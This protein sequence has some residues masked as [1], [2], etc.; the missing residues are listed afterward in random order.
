MMPQPCCELL[1]GR[2]IEIIVTPNRPRSVESLSSLPPLA[3]PVYACALGLGLGLFLLLTMGGMSEWDGDDALYIM[4]ARN[5]VLGLPYA[6]TGYILNPG[7]VINPGAYPPGFPLLLAPVYWL[8]GVSL[9][10]MKALC[11]VCFAIFLAIFVRI[12]QR[13]VSPGLALATA[14]ALGVN[15]YIWGFK[16]TLYSELPFMLM[17]YGALLLIDTVQ[18]S[19]RGTRR[20]AYI[21]GAIATLAF[22]YLIR[23]IGIVIFPAA[24]LSAVLAAKRPLAGTLSV[25]GGAALVIVIV[26]RI[27]PADIGAYVGYFRDFDLN[28]VRVAAVRYWGVRGIIIGN[29]VSN[30]LPHIARLVEAALSILAAIGLTT[31]IIRRRV[32]VFETFFVGYLAFLLIY[33]INLER[34]RYSLPAWPL[35]FLYCAAGLAVVMRLCGRTT[36]RLLACGITLVV[37]GCY[38]LQYSTALSIPVPHPIEAPES[39][40]LFTAIRATVPADAAILTRKPTTIALFT[41]R[42]A[43]IWAADDDDAHLWNYMAQHHVGYIVQERFPVVELKQ[44]QTAFLNGVIRR[45]QSA[46]DLVFSN[47]WYNLYRVR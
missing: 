11:I 28:G 20:G 32:S 47:D 7:N 42:A 3:H 6:K 1:H 8:F 23:A 14:A 12:A 35:A 13:Y 24:L 26:Q 27:Y 21:A 18:R 2:V 5:I 10:K 46:L 44:D 40:A 30:R 39:Q 22:A 41:E 37:I 19:D 36:R 33:P 31:Q 15:P 45:N 29:S 16:D 34:D 38:A 9:A 17:C 4:N 25:L 43:T